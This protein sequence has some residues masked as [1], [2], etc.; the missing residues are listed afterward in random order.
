MSSFILLLILLFTYI[1]SLIFRGWYN[2]SEQIGERGEAKVHEILSQ[3][4]KDYYVLDDIV[5]R[6]KRGTTQIDHVVVSKFG[7]FAIETKNYRGEVY[8][9]DNRRQWTQIIV[10]KVRYKRKWYKTYTYITKKKFYNPV[11]QSLGHVY[12]LKNNLSQWPHLKVIP[13]VVFVGSANLSNVKSNVIVIYAHSLITT[14]LN[15][16]T[17]YLSESNVQEVIKLLTEKNVR[18]LVDNKT[19]IYNIYATQNELN[20][21]VQ[22]GICPK[23]GGT[24]LLRNG[25]YGSFYGC[26]NYP[27]C[28][29]TIR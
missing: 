27:K 28:K 4:P 21:K 17:E 10:T 15:H 8:G 29:F 25:R 2:S 6:T 9:D 13:I 7:I 20:R 22:S 23:C 18:N 5:L 26:S 3:L 24:L 1:G 11:K 14:I 12:G 16:R 19:H